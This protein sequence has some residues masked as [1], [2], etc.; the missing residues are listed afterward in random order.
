MDRLEQLCRE[1]GVKLTI[2]RRIVLEV[3]EAAT[4]HPSANEIHRR[5]RHDRPVGAA[6]VYRA[7]NRLA[8]AGLIARL[9]FKDGK[10]RYERVG[11][12][13][14]P[15]L[16]DVGSGAV[17]EVDDDGGLV[18]LMEEEARRRGYR[19]VDYRLTMLGVRTSG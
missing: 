11:R 13:P 14:H 12:T 19:L 9:V 1:R 3:L 4:D 8:A 6:T 7:L 5:A 2:Q 10:V 17:V 18:Q 15:H 16:I